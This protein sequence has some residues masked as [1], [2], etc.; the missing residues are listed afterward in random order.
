LF[1]L[2][3]RRRPKD[4]LGASDFDIRHT[5]NVA[6]VYSPHVPWR[7]LGPLFN[8][9]TFGS[10]LYARTGFP[11]DVMV[12]ETTSGFVIANQRPNLLPG[13]PLWIDDAKLAGRRELNP[14][15]FSSTVKDG[16]GNL[17][18][19]SVRGWG[20]WQTDASVTREFRPGEGLRVALR[21]EAFNLLNH[22]LFADPVRYR[23]SPLFGKSTS[24]LN[25]MLG[26]GSPTSGQSPAFQMGGPRSFQ[27]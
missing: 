23:S 4:D 27:A 22:P 21:V 6:A 3:A 10:S 15:A 16:F 2:T 5:V 18:R 7:R 13:N 9:W 24:P 14:K 19:N 26:S 11:L 12:S 25:L 1:Q 20:M 8:G 17:G